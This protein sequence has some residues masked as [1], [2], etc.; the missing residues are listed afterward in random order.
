MSSLTKIG[1]IDEELLDELL[2]EQKKLKIINKNKR[3]MK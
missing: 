3:N 2:E 1:K